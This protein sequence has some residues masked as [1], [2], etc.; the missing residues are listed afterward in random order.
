MARILV[1]DDEHDIVRA[2]VK[3]LS[4]RGHDVDTARDGNGL[5][6]RVEA[7]PPDAVIIDAALPGVDGIEL[8]RQLK[9]NTATRHVPVVLMSAA[10][11]SL[12]DGPSADEYVVKPF[13]RE[14]L[15]QNVERLLKRHA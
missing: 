1:I 7:D 11:L 9:T 10:Y 4:A 8:V 12:T 13:T 2:I 15:V 5:I 6:D 3:I 14:I